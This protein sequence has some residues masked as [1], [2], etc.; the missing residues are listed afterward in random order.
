M[1][2]T[3]ERAYFQTRVNPDPDEMTGT[4]YLD[5]IVRK[6]GLDRM[7][8]TELSAPSDRTV[9][10]PTDSP[11]GGQVPKGKSRTP[12]ERA[13]VLKEA[14]LFYSEP[15]RHFPAEEQAAAAQ[16]KSS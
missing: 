16:K 11:M 3:T 15:E 9:S 10:G 5:A 4:Q 1:S 8:V 13:H 14:E 2:E 7:S 6:H 12:D